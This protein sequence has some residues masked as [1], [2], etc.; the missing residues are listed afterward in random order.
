MGSSMVAA[1]INALRSLLAAATSG[2]DRE[3]KI[4][5]KHFFSGAAAYANGYIFM[6]LTSVGVALKLPEKSRAEL[7]HLGGTPL[8][9][10]P[11]GPV[12]KDY[13]IV[14]KRIVK[15][16]DAIAP[17]IIKSVLFSQTFPK[18][19]CAKRGARPPGCGAH[20]TKRVKAHVLAS[21]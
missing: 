16:G 21:K 2:L 20:G 3:V 18:R 14:P 9:Y 8:R 5:C 1:Q 13:V 17:W 6:T 19:P 15:D 7:S 4:E 11:K 10:F 12:K